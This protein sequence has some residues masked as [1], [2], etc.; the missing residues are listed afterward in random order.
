MSLSDR[1]SSN[2]SGRA[3]GV[4]ST[5]LRVRPS[6]REEGRL[7]ANLVCFSLPFSVW[8]FDEVENPAE[9]LVEHSGLKRVGQ[10]LAILPSRDELGVFQQIEMVRDA[11]CGHGE[12]L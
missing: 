3:P 1:A 5:R 11:G 7:R 10:E 9:R 4:P 8:F 2:A 12:R 6:A